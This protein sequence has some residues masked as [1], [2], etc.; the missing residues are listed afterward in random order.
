MKSMPGNSS[1]PGFSKISA[2]NGNPQVAMPTDQ[3][4]L[5]NIAAAQYYVQSYPGIA[6]V[7][8]G[9]YLP[10]T[11]PY[12]MPA[13]SPMNIPAMTYATAMSPYGL[14]NPMS[15]ADQT[16]PKM[17]T[18]PTFMDAMPTQQ[19]QMHMP[20]GTMYSAAPYI[21]VGASF[22]NASA[23]LPYFDYTNIPQYANPSPAIV[24][25]VAP[26]QPNQKKSAP[27]K[28]NKNCC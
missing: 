13:T 24:P 28:K 3:D 20:T 2:V 18:L 25:T 17:S 22:Y 16:I 26:A 21:P 6:P 11:A 27:K 1:E 14:S 4:V 7:A 8:G 10:T 5:Q 9:Y 19:A 12:Q 15:P 23:G